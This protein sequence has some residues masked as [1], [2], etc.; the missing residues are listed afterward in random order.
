MGHLRLG[1]L[2]RSQRW[3]KVLQLL[4]SGAPIDEVARETFWAAYTGLGKVPV[5][6]GFTQ[7]LTTI[8]RFVDALQSKNP[9]TALRQSGFDVGQDA[10]LFDYIGSFQERATRAAIDVR[11]H[12]DLAYMAQESFT[13]V[14]ME[15][16]GSS[17]QT[18]FGLESG[19]AGKSLK[20]SLSGQNLG[21]TMHE[22]FVGFTQKYLSYYLG[23]A[24]PARVGISKSLANIDKHSEFGKSFDLFVRQT[25]RIT[26]EFSPGWFG[27]ARWEDRLTH[28]E[29]SK[30]AHTAFKKIQSEFK[31]GAQKNG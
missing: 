5:D 22:F 26:D 9:T 8:F 10:S 21:R 28:M 2:P 15:S 7:T 16:A 11:A 25:V 20:T 24:T 4:D 23:R 3:D 13:R 14:L 6:A 30:F 27:K 29:V 17:L 18:L 12:S 1:R 31:R 19:D